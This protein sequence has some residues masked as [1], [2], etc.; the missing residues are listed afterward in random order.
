VP[1]LV[2]ASEGLIEKLLLV[3]D[4]KVIFKALSVRR[5]LHAIEDEAALPGSCWERVRQ[6][7]LQTTYMSGNA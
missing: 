3:E 5:A 4:V 6:S 7:H 2:V 1:G